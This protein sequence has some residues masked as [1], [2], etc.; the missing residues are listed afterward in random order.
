[1]TT[2]SNLDHALAVSGGAPVRTDRFPPWPAFEEEE[3]EAAAAVLR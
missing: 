3:I 1:M 2:V